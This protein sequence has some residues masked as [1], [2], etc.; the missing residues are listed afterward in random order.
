MKTVF[1]I[2]LLALLFSMGACTH[3]ERQLAIE[4]ELKPYKQALWTG[5]ITRKEYNVVRE[6]IKTTYEIYGGAT[7]NYPF[8]NGFFGDLD[9]KPTTVTPTSAPSPSL[10]TAK[11][12]GSTEE[13]IF[14]PIDD[15]YPEADSSTFDSEENSA[16]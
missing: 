10:P 1:P 11:Q 2:A 15:V 13:E 16:E 12:T 8:K 4:H 3:V 9:E 6:E 7:Y 14:D 5:A